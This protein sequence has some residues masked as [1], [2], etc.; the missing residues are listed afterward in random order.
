MEELININKFEV[1]KGNNEN[2]K[3]II[4]INSINLDKNKLDNCINNGNNNI[5]INQNELFK[6]TVFH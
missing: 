5:Y 6:Y 2:K 4:N 1:K 3:N